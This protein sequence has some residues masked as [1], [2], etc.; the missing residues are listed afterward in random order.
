MNYDDFILYLLDDR[1]YIEVYCQKYKTG[2]IDVFP[3]MEDFPPQ[4]LMYVFDNELGGFS[5][6]GIENS[7][8]D[9]ISE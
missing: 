4:G 1:L 7:L 9:K 3:N 2:V 8:E 6:E 5:R